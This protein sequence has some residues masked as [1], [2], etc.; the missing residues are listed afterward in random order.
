[1]VMTL[2]ARVQ[3]LLRNQI[4]PALELDGS[5]IEVTEVFNGI[6]SVRLGEICSSCPATLMTVI[7]QME[8]E[9]KRLM[10]EIDL[11]EAIL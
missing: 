6:A 11:I 4:A 9:L 5:T 2:K 10:P 1:M 8:S 7:G 3:E